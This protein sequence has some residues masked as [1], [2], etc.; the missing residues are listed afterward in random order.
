MLIHPGYFLALNSARERRLVNLVWL[1]FSFNGRI[2]RVQFWLG[3]VGASVGCML[4]LF[5]LGVLFGPMSSTN[6]AHAFSSFFYMLTP[7]WLLSS[8]SGFALQVKRL[9]DRGRSGAWTMLPMLP[10]VMITWSM[11]TAIVSA[12]AALK[13]G[14]AANLE[15]IF[16]GAIFS[17]GIWVLILVLVWIFMFVD[18]GCL[19]GRAEANKYGNPPGGGLGGGAPVGGAPI[20]GV[21]IPGQPSRA[22]AQPAPSA[23]STLM[24]AENAIERAIAAQK[25]EATAPSASLGPRPAMATAQPGGGPRPATP[26]SFGRRASR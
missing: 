10:M 23:A 2:N 16:F 12:I 9:H 17:A 26:G 6:P 8:W 22:S 1:L 25:R 3:M 18:L 7:V 13:N 24:S 15:V 21:T 19:P 11:V 14:A 20:G 4:L 5:M